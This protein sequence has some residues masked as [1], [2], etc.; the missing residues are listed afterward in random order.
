MIRGITRNGFTGDIN[1]HL[2]DQES[3]RA[4]LSLKTD[5]W[6]KTLNPLL[7]LRRK[8]Y[9][10]IV[11]GIP[12][13]F[14]PDSRVHVREFVDENHGTLDTATKIVWANKHSIELGKP[15]SSLIIHLTDPIAANH[16]I[17]HRLCFKHTLKLTEKSTKRIRQC[18]T[19]LD[20][21]HYA[22]SCSETI[23]ACSHCA[24]NHPY[25][26]CTRLADPVRCVN[27]IHH[28]LDTEF[29]ANP[30]ATILDMNENQKA[31]C[32]HSAFSNQCPLRRLQV[33]KN[34]HMS[35]TYDLPSHE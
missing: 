8:V 26:A 31:L 4:V 15:F 33:A 24:G 12:T 28:T 11:H 32:A 1:L 7:L 25:H 30:E 13:S 5:D 9:P 3:L 29:S 20:F 34:A 21:G 35:D 23:R 10:V 27:C 19:C 16:A 6:V 17:T 14:K 18:Y 22:K 2:N